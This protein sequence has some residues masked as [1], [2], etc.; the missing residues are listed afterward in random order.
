MPAPLLLALSV[1]LA[2][3]APPAGPP[4]PPSGTHMG[5]TLAMTMTHHGAPWLTRESRM[6]EERPDLLHAALQLEAGDTACDIGAG[7][8]YHT[9]PMARMVAPG[10]LAL[11]VDI[12]PEMLA[13]LRARAAEAGLDNVRAVHNTQ[14][15]SGLPAG[16]CDLALM[17][18]VY[19][20]L[21]DPPAMLASLHAA[22]KPDGELVVVEYREEDPSVPIKPLHKMS[23][24]QVHRELKAGGFKLVRERDD[25]PWQHVMVYQRA[26]GPGP[27]RAPTPWTRPAQ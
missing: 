3:A 10:G 17:V 11:G 27:A 14:G 23:K 22:L 20:E 26:D 6:V 2:V 13:L 4:A 25:L 19:H 8:G 5:R 12:Q 18:D 21:S 24:A 7:N 15:G 16:T 1:V 9:L